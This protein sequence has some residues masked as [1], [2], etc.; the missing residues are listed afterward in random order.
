[1]NTIKMKS[2]DPADNSM[3]KQIIFTIVMVVL[4]Y[5]CSDG[6]LHVTCTEPTSSKTESVVIETS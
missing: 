4:F 6:N 1:M 3:A 5:F 2:I